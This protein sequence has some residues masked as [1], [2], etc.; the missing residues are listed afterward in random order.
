M[1]IELKKFGTALISRPSGKE[2]WL[3]FQSSLKDVSEHEEV[4]I[5]FTG[6]L[7][8]TPSWADEFLTPLRTRF[9][10]KVKLMD[11]D[12]ASV[13]ATMTILDKPVGNA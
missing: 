4:I 8:L 7:V 9:K 5:D 12:N 11:T 10:D 13:E 1:I 6:V 2:A 3:A